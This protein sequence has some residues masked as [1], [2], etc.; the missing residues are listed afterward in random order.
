[1]SDASSTVLVTG[2]NGQLGRLVVSKLLTS[3]EP[4]RI[5]AGVRNPGKA[6][7]LEALGVTIRPFDYDQ[8]D[9]LEAAL[10]DVDKLLLISSSEVGK[11]T[12]QHRNVIEAAARAQVKLLAYT[13]ILHADSNPMELAR[14]H[15]ETEALLEEASVPFVLLRNGWYLENYTGNLPAALEQGAL[16]GS[17]GNGRIAAASRQDLA[18]AAAAVLTADE[19]QAGQVYELAGDDAF[20]LT[21]LAAEV[22]WQAGRPFRYDNLSEAEH[23]KVLTE[24]G[25]PEEF[26]GILAN[27]DSAASRGALFDNSGQLSKLIGRPTTSYQ[28]AIAQ[29][30]GKA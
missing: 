24:I 15:V 23:A 2:A 9:T 1:M 30:L 19:P 11:R 22:S 14:E 29:A 27:S 21:E 25:L 8:P 5:I 12:G 6:S 4:S 20:T 16:I 10:D 7:D 13:S 28:S 18:E 3:L 17:A 26:A